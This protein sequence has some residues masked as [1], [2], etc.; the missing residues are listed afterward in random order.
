MSDRLKRVLAD[1]KA[2]RQL[3]EALSKRQANGKK[4]VELNGEIFTVTSYR[5]KPRLETKKPVEQADTES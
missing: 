4:Q 3:L 5:I 2:K 1:K